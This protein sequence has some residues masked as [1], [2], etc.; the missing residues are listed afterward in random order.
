M[1]RYEIEKGLLDGTYSTKDLKEVWN[2]YYNEYLH[3]TVP[4]DVEGVLQDIHWSHGS[5]GYF[6]TY[7]LGSFYAAQFFAAAEKQIPGL[8]ADIIKGNYTKLLTWLREK[9]HHFGRFYTSNELCEKVTGKPLDF[10]YFLDYATKKYGN[11]Y[12]L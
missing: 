9:I 2:R 7:S 11:I 1:I 4:N 10:K 8:E 3:V 12:T 6:P 5:F